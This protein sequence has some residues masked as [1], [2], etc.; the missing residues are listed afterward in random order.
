MGA[1]DVCT[2]ILS[3]DEK[4]NEKAFPSSYLLSMTSAVYF[5]NCYTYGKQPYSFE[6]IVFRNTI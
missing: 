2:N 6:G 1:H 5:A 4:Q 3:K